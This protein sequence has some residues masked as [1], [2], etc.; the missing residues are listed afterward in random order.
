MTLKRHSKFNAESHPNVD[1][2]TIITTKTEPWNPCHHINVMNWYSHKMHHSIVYMRK[3][4]ANISTRRQ[5]HKE[6]AR[7]HQTSAQRDGMYLSNASRETNINLSITCF[8]YERWLDTKMVLIEI[9]VQSRPIYGIIFKHKLS[10]TELPTSQI[11]LTS[12][13]TC[14]SNVFKTHWYHQQNIKREK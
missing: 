9:Q 8:W 12:R 1:K 14:M 5:F 7:K 2:S 4:F 3:I 6:I 13:S 10:A 11:W